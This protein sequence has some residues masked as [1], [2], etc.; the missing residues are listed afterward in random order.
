LLSWPD[1]VIT[2][3]C[4]VAFVS[5]RRPN[6]HAFVFPMLLLHLDLFATL[7]GEAQLA[8]RGRIAVLLWAG[9]A[10]DFAL[11]GKCR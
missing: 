8:P 7:L 9:S 5:G 10:L 4:S 3:C 2:A 11:V 6:F 1:A